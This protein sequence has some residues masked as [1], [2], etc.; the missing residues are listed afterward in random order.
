VVAYDFGVKRNILRMLTSRLQSDRGACADHRCRS[1]GA[2]PGRRVPVERP[3]RP[4]PCDY[5]IAAA[6]V[7]MEKKIPLFGICLGHQIMGW[8]PAPRP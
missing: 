4:E 2:E 7:F 1:A 6:K 5:A 3:W 8:P